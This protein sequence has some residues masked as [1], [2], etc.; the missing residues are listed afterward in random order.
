M[1]IHPEGVIHHLRQ[2]NGI[3]GGLFESMLFCERVNE[4]E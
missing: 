3:S 1:H 2:S 4:A